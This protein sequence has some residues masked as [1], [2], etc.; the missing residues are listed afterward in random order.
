MTEGESRHSRPPRGPGATALLALATALLAASASGPV[1]A[2]GASWESESAYLNARLQGPLALSADGQ[3]RVHVDAANVLHRVNLDDPKQDFHVALPASVHTLAASRS[4]RKVALVTHGGCIALVDFGAGPAPTPRVSWRPVPPQRSIDHA[5]PGQR[6]TST[7]P[8]LDS[9]APACVEAH[10]AS[11][12]DV[13]ALSSD[14]R[15]L[16]TPS[17][18]V[19]LEAHRIVASL[20]RG[21]ETPVL[22]RFVDRDTRLL[23]VDDAMMLGDAERLS[24]DRLTIALWDLKTSALL[25]LF[26]R[27]RDLRLRLSQLAELPSGSGTVYSVTQA[28]ESYA[29]SQG[30]PTELTAWRADSCAALPPRRIPADGWTG[31]AVDPA[32]RWIAGTR[33]VASGSQ[34][35]PAAGRVTDELVV[36]DIAT[37]RELARSTWK[38]ALHGLVASAD[39]TRLHALAAASV[40]P[41]DQP[42]DPPDPALPIGRVITI[43]LPSAAL[44]PAP[45]RPAAWPAAGCAIAREGPHAREVAHADRALTP[46]W[47]L[48]AQREASASNP[49]PDTCIPL[50]VMRDGSVWLDGDRTITQVDA[51]TG[52]RGRTLPTPRSDK[53]RS[54]PLPASDGWFN[55]QGDTLSWRP[56]D[57]SASGASTRR[58]VDTRPGR[59]IILLQRQGD[60]VLVAWAHQAFGPKPAGAEIPDSRP[61]TYVFYDAKGRAVSESLGTEDVQGDQWATSDELQHAATQANSEACHDETGALASG[62]DWR[63]DRFN[64]IAAW[65]CGP[66]AGDAR[67]VLW[68][69]IDVRPRSDADMDAVGSRAIV[70]TDGAF[71]VVQDGLKLRLFDASDRREFGSVV[72]PQDTP[73][74]AVRLDAARGLMLVETTKSSSGGNLSML[75]AYAWR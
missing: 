31:I 65:S 61:T 44:A 74:V 7:Q 35:A 36:V 45:Q 12:G 56:F 41:Y 24:P 53:I 26:D 19:D 73:P 54:V 63:L 43:D 21:R 32:G 46:L 30:G 6:G 18:V 29:G 13:I 69:D 1:R 27:K 20:P 49:C 40:E 10:G 14:G 17:E 3:W 39:G 37:G 50:I 67:I 28:A 5:S 34:G 48:Q 68:S 60:S 33:R 25:S 64:S 8:W 9:P 62:F 58:I 2:D 22:L 59:E 42:P 75:H 70:A 51:A 16:A 72:L 23:T 55:A 4:G 47:S 71:A 11:A 57:A 38:H 15:L 66:A 52:H